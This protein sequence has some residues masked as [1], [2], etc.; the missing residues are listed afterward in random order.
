[1]KKKVKPVQEGAGGAGREIE[2]IKET[3]K[4]TP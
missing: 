1:L 2:I 4:P 3:V